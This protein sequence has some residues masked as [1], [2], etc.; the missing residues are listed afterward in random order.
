M[1]QS[2]LH[3]A[4]QVLETR[5]LAQSALDMNEL[6]LP[7][8]ESG[9]RYDVAYQQTTQANARPS[10]IDVTVTI[11]DTKLQGSAAWLSPDEQRD[12]ELIFHFPLDYQLPDYQELD[13]DTGC[14]R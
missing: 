13:I 12:N 6:T 7:N 2:R 9:V 11:E 3:Y 14:I 4:E 5:C 8:E 1:Q 10:G